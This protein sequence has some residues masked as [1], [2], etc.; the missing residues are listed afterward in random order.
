MSLRGHKQ[1]KYIN[2]VIQFP[3]FVSSKPH[4]QAEFQYIESGL[5]LYTWRFSRYSASIHWLVH[6][7][8]TSNN[9]T[10]SRQ[11]PWA[12][13]IAKTLTSNGKQFTEK[14]EM[15]TAVARDP[16]WPDVVA[17]ISA[18]FSKFCF[19]VVLL[20]NKSLND[21]SLGEQWILL[22]SRSQC[23]PRLRLG[24]TKFTVPF[25]TSH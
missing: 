6:C 18:R 4:C 19:C 22:P 23:F 10:V 14:C 24:K 9:G 17:G 1:K 8:M 5:L 21:W 13:N 2:M 3:L 11:M 20:F 7:H 25:G 16:R 12:G 15:L